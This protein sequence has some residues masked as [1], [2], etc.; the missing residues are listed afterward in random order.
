[1]NELLIK[2]LQLTKALVGEYECSSF[3]DEMAVADIIQST[4]RL[5][6]ILQTKEN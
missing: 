5:I 2:S 1:M 4:S 3:N 6:S